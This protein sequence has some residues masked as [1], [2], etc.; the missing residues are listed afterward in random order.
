EGVVAASDVVLVPTI[1]TVLSLRAV[2]R[3]I[4]W[5]DHAEARSDM[6]V[7]FSMV[8]RRKALHRRACEW[9]TRT[10]DFFMSGR[11]PYASMVEQTTVRRTPLA[12]F[13]ARDAA[14][15]AF[16]DVWAELAVRIKQR[17]ER[18]DMAPGDRWVLMLRAVESLIERVE[19]FE[20]PETGASA[21]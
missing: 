11:I 13:A 8:D 14:T 15:V 4:K 12:A 7:F 3:M 21:P 17:E 20:E 19:R 2:A 1:P 18:G 16:A 9:G 6:A 5:A 10:R